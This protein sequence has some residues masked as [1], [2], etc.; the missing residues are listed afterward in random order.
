MVDLQLIYEKAIADIS[1]VDQRLHQLM[2][3]YEL[4]R[5]DHQ[6]YNDG[7]EGLPVKPI[8]KSKNYFYSFCKAH[9]KLIGIENVVQEFAN[10]F[11]ANRRKRRWNRIDV[12]QYENILTRFVNNPDTSTLPIK[13]VYEQLDK[14]CECTLDLIAFETLM[15]IVN[16]NISDMY[17]DVAPLYED[18]TLSQVLQVFRDA[19]ENESLTIDDVESL[20]ERLEEWAAFSDHK[21]N[22]DYGTLY[23]MSILGGIDYN[24]TIQEAVVAL[25][26]CV[27]LFHASNELALAFI[28]GGQNALNTIRYGKEQIMHGYD[29]ISGEETAIDEEQHLLDLLRE[30]I[31]SKYQ[32][33]QDGYQIDIGHGMQIVAKIVVQT[34]KEFIEDVNAINSLRRKL[35]RLS[36][37]IVANENDIM[38]ED[39]IRY[40]SNEVKY[41]I[42]WLRWM[43]AKKYKTDTDKL[44]QV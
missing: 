1:L 13:L 40:S 26:K 10:D 31:A 9:P 44:K 16:E 15:N 19:F 32:S 11:N 24:P 8:L 5:K 29:T 7:Q 28:E 30:S 6:E 23:A 12:H 14:I 33:M 27:D 35:R 4:Y 42:Y 39:D 17:L 34:N 43:I 22:S 3:R 36:E 21:C 25:N 18:Y 2:R 37:E 41:I 38:H 20:C